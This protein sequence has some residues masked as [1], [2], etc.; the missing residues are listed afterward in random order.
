MTNIE[1]FK[2]FGSFIDLLNHAGVGDVVK[3]TNMIKS[4]I[5]DLP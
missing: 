3:I 4:F 1:I 2:F 5:N